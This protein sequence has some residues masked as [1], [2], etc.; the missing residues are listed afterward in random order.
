MEIFLFFVGF[1]KVGIFFWYFWFYVRFYDLFLCFEVVSLVC[2]CF[3][4]SGDLGIYF[5]V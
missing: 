5:R 2:L 3:K 4:K 1:D